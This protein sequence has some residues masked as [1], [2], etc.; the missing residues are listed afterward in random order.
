MIS[1][2]AP[3][4]S[5]AASAGGAGLPIQ[6]TPVSV[7]SGAGS[8]VAS[9]SNRPVDPRLLLKSAAAAIAA[10]SSS[11]IVPTLPATSSTYTLDSKSTTE[12]SVSE[13]SFSTSAAAHTSAESAR[14]HHHHSSR[15]DARA[16]KVNKQPAKL[17]P[18]K[19][20]EG[21]SCSFGANCR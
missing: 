19:L 20:N 7:A 13:A 10:A 3:A 17:C 18:F 8:S 1:S 4:Q 9:N 16:E 6:T 11:S 12:S 5:T 14:H 15:S 2:V 21:G